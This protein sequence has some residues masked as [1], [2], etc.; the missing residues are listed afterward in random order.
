M[1]KAPRK[2]IRRDKSG[3]PTG[4]GP[5]QIRPTDLSF[6][7][8]AALCCGAL[9]VISANLSSLLP[10]DWVAALHASQ[11]DAATLAQLRAEV[12]RLDATANSLR[13][14]NEAMQ[15]R[16]ALLEQQ[17][18]TVAQRVGALEV[19]LPDRIEA[20]T[21]NADAVDTQSVT[22][23][24]PETPS[25]EDGNATVQAMPMP[26]PLV[27]GA[28]LEAPTASADI[29]TPQ[30]I[31]GTA[32]GVALGGPVDSYGAVAAWAVMMRKAGTLLVGLDP[33]LAEDPGGRGRRLVAGP[34][35]SRVQAEDL[36]GH[37]AA[38]GM[39]C[40]PVPFKGEPLRE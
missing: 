7:G 6:W 37:V 5:D 26:A 21:A 8:V 33:V 16:F 18:G 1:A 4:R 12:S 20:S 31:G 22:A 32:F 24:I 28:G 27:P 9:A 23:S 19:G 34:I 39:A 29:A 38:I 40:Q 15:V 17:N 35:A 13:R 25:I 10:A 14:D 3:R 2:P 36:C 30:P 11:S